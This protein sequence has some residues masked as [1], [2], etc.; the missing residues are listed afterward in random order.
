MKN[1]LRAI[2]LLALF[3]CQAYAQTAKS[4]TYIINGKINGVDSGK[5]YSLSPDRKL[6]DSAAIVK[7]KFV[8]S[9]KLD[10]PKRKWFMIQPGNWAFEAFVDAPSITFNID[11]SG[12]QH[13]YTA[14][15]DNPIIW[16]V[17][18]TG[19]PFA[20]VY[21]IY[22]REAGLADFFPLM[23]KLNS[24]KKDSL[25]YFNNKL[26][27]LRQ[28]FPVKQKAWVDNYVRQ[29]PESV[30]GI[31][32]FEEYYNRLH[33]TSPIYL[34]SMIEQFSGSAKASSHYKALMNK[35]S[36][37]ESIQIGKP[38]PDFTLLKRDKHKF[39]LS[40]TRGSVVMLDFW[41]SWCKPCRAGIPYWKEVYSKYHRKGFEIVS[42]T[43][44]KSWKS[45]KLALDQE[46]MPWTQVIDYVAPGTL[47][48]VVGELYST[49]FLPHF[50][51]ID[52]KGKILIASGD[53][54]A[55]KRKIAETLSK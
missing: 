31:Y 28:V 51:L 4:P 23:K 8:L 32:I 41:A 42:I 5:I 19:S 2:T 11:T 30:P 3:S 26:D 16:E 15:T 45:W 55:V 40:T 7:G 43:D 25:A 33:D 48:G 53:E 17:K 1:V 38:A 9:G 37:L 10:L 20:D 18:E 39:K 14:G 54:H 24:A 52:K 50:V 6:I 34:R 47:S 12:A 29:N 44:D 49:H 22:L 36:I 46:K 21:D 27:S 13:Y 35:L